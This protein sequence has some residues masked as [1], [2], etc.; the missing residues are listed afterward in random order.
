[1][2]E[3]VGKEMSKLSRSVTSMNDMKS[4]LTKY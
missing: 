3:D 1:M 2:M 4:W